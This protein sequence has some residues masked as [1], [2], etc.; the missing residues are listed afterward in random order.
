MVPPAM[1]VTTKKRGVSRSAPWS[2]WALA[3]ALTAGCS[4]P[5]VKELLEGDRL[6]REGQ[7]HEAIKPLQKASAL[8]PNNALAWNQ[9]GVAHHYAGLPDGAETAYRKALA[10]NPNL[11]AARW[12]LACLCLELNRAADAAQHFGSVLVF[13]AKNA[14]F[15]LMHAIALVRAGKADEAERSF[16]SY[17]AARGAQ[18]EAL[19]GLAIA[20]W[21]RNRPQEAAAS[22]QNVLQIAPQH[23]PA[24][25]NL[26]ILHHTHLGNKPLALKYYQRYLSFTPEPPF[27][28]QVAQVAKLLE[29]ELHGA[30]SATTNLV[31][32]P[33]P[34]PPTSPPPPALTAPTNLAR[35]P[36]ATNPA[37][38]PSPPPRTNRPANPEAVAAV[39]RPATS[40][41]PAAP[42]ITT[43]TTTPPAAPEPAPPPP[44]GAARRYTYL[45]PPK[46]EPGDRTKALTHYQAGEA[47]RQAQN[48]ADAQKHYEAAVKADPTLFEAHAMLGRVAMENRDWPRALS[49]YEQALVLQP[50]AASTR[51]NFALALHQAG[52][53][54][55]AVAEFER[56][57]AAQPQETNGRMFVANIYLQELHDVPKARAHY[58]RLLELQPNHPQAA[59]LREWL[60][61]HP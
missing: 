1:M 15:Q 17:L 27:R 20:Q 21:M 9:L 57:Y 33:T 39:T 4:P 47:A 48:W 49:A 44:P 31:T 28:A 58:Q 7:Y 5:G 29:A 13:D 37:V 23:R 24:T 32:T 38:A 19:N 46:P 6:V 2:W 11:V 41:P 18:P 54:A 40:A 61:Q 25:L 42:A 35:G 30:A 10:I 50:E 59:A 36:A 34:P 45:R 55:D 56:F 8:L 12:N 14:D 60:R 22:L 26:A 3:L 51:F 53:A 43:T 16:K 52:F